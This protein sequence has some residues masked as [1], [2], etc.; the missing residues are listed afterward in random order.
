MPAPTALRTP[1]AAPEAIPLP[2]PA[3]DEEFVIDV[4]QSDFA[5]LSGPEQPQSDPEDTEMAIDEEGRPKFA[6]GKD[7][8][9]CP[10]TAT[11]QASGPWA[12]A[13]LT[14]T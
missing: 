12:L 2:A 9:R 14:V 3:Q 6:P 1:T 11:L 7:V 8:V 13:D 4:E 5:N 10:V